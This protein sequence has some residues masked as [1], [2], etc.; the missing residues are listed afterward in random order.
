MSGSNYFLSPLNTNSLS[1]AEHLCTPCS[2]MKASCWGAAA[3]TVPSL[4]W[5]K[6]EDNWLQDHPG[7]V[8]WISWSSRR[9]LDVYKVPACPHWHLLLQH[10]CLVVL[11]FL[12][13][14]S[15]WPKKYQKDDDSF[16]YVGFYFYRKISIDEA[17]HLWI[18]LHQ[19]WSPR[20]ILKY[21][22]SNTLGL[23]LFLS[24]LVQ[25]LKQGPVLLRTALK[26][27]RTQWKSYQQ[28]LLSHPA[29]M[30]RVANCLLN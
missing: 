12:Q 16:Q 25:R 24:A 26:I 29:G 17:H 13:R 23:L 8:T 21:T 9:T 10:T 6:E 1:L 14:S 28:A 5:G 19:R 22:I 18:K 2:R 27:T 4:P 11:W 15:E 20:H 30:S 7:A 3:S